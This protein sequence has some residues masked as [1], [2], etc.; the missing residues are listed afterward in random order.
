MKRT[1]RKQLIRRLLLV[2]R[3]EERVIAFIKKINVKDCI[4]M[5]ADAWESLTNMNL[6]N[7][8]NKVWPETEVENHRN[9]FEEESDGVLEEVTT[10]FRNI[11]GFEQCE[12][13]DAD[14]W[15]NNDANDPGF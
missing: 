9:T 6:K 14:E 11:P 10:L 5:L 1:Y 13:N 7:G 12:A 15:L 2:E 4:Y 8:W 3:E